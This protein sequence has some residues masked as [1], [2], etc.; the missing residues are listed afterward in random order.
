MIRFP[1]PYKIGEEYNP[2]NSDEKLRCGAATY[3]FIQ[4]NCPDIRVP[5]LL[6]FAFSGNDCVSL[7]THRYQQI[8]PY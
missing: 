5:K 8:I 4:E 6:G 2:G 7:P 1:L 3:V